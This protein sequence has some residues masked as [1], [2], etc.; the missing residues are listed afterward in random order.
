MNTVKMD[1]KYILTFFYNSDYDTDI[2]NQL[3]FDTIEEVR[4]AFLQAMTEFG[5]T[6]N[7][8][9]FSEYEFNESSNG[10]TSDLSVWTVYFKTESEHSWFTNVLAF[11][12]MEAENKVRNALNNKCSHVV[13]EHHNGLDSVIMARLY[14]YA[15]FVDCMSL[16]NL[17][18]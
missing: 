10:P 7:Q 8:V 15:Q 3:E 4:A 2:V 6:F 16:H 1:K 17:I 14:P 12:G 5:V 11:S 13:A 18:H 9:E